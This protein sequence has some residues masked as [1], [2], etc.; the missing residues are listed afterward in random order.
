MHDEIKEI[1]ADVKVI[2]EKQEETNLHLA[3]YNTLLDVHIQGV[4]DLQERVKPIESH[5]LF[6]RGLFKLILALAALF[7]PIFIHFR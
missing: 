2:R 1:K 5:V 6:I 7:I 3:K 4:K